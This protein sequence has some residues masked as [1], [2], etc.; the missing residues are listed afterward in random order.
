MQG[1]HRLW[2]HQSIIVA[3]PGL[4]LHNRFS[5]KHVTNL[6][7]VESTPILLCSY[8][9]HFVHLDTYISTMDVFQAASLV[10]IPCIFRVINNICNFMNYIIYGYFYIALQQLLVISVIA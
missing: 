7:G 8:H 2:E 4:M 1:G 9:L 10:L 5:K 6:N 3:S